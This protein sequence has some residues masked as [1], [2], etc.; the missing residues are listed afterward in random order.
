M[1]QHV[2][3]PRIILSLV[4]LLL[5]CP[6]V[7]GAPSDALKG[8]RSFGI[9]VEPPGAVLSSQGYTESWIKERARVKLK[10]ARVSVDLSNRAT[11]LYINANAI[12]Q[13]NGAL[14]YNIRVDFN[15]P[16]TLD[17]NA[18]KMIATTWSNGVM[19][20]S[21]RDLPESFKGSL[22]KALDSFISDF[23]QANPPLFPS[24]PKEREQD[25]F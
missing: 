19:G 5:T 12:E 25:H 1:R 13:K 17:R 18:Y 24:S 14:S 2:L 16:V 21:H 8:V 15:E 11:W 22:D 7:A 3:A 6:K 20:T 4:L 23:Q 10:A 9:I